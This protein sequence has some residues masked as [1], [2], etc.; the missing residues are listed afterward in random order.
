MAEAP[1]GLIG[2]RIP[3]LEDD[4]LT[5]GRGRYLDDL[6]PVGTLH[7]R[8]VRSQRA[9]A[10]LTAVV[11][12]EYEPLPPEAIVITGKD[13]LGLGIQADARVVPK[14]IEPHQR[15][16]DNRPTEL[17]PAWQSSLQPALAHEVVRYVGEPIAAVLHP[18]PYVV[19]DAA[20]AVSVHYEDLEPV[21][22]MRGAL[23]A[24][25][26]IV[27]EGWRDNVFI[28]RHRTYGDLKAARERGKHTVRI[29]TRTNRQAGVPLENRGCLAMPDATG[30]G[31]VL[32]T[33]SQMPHLVRTYVSRALGIPENLLRV[34]APEV[35]GGFG[36]KGHVFPD[37]VLVS[38]LAR[39][40]QRPV[41][42]TED[43]VE[44]LLSSIHARDHAHRLEAFVDDDGRVHGI[45]A[46]IV[47][48]A[49]AYSVFPWTAGS[50]SGMVPKVMIGPYDIQDVEFEDIAIA[51]NKS[52]LGTYR[53]VGRP[54]ATFSIERLMD[55]VA[56]QLGLDAV[57]VRRRNLITEFPYRAANGLLYDSGSYLDTLNKV[58]EEL[59]WEVARATDQG[60]QRYRRGVG[61]SVFNEQT[62][63]GTP[64]FEVRGTP[65]ETGYQGMRVE[66]NPDGTSVIFMGLQSHGQ[67]LETTLAQVM[68]SELGVLPSTVKVV[69]GDTGNSPYSVGTWGSRGAVLGGG[70]VARAAREL[71]AKVLKIAAF[72]LDVAEDDL[73]I[74]RGVVR[75]KKNP[76]Q[77]RTI[78]QIA[79]IAIRRAAKMP[80]GLAPGLDAL[81]YVDGPDRGTFSNACH[82]AQVVLDTWTGRVRIERY[83]VAEDCGTMLN[84]TIVEG[85][86]QGGVAQGIGN[87]LLE[88]FNYSDDGQPMSATFMDYLMPTATDVPALEI[89]HF[90]SPS[91]WTENGVKG[92]GEAGAI[93]PLA[94]VAAAVSHAVGAQ[95]YETPMQMERV[96]A[97]QEGDVPEHLTWEYWH[98]C[99]RLR[100]FWDDF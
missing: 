36:V 39:R 59:D 82:G 87:A 23:A 7:L 14:V 64:D 11:P 54:S 53:G 85:Q 18:D 69:H 30:R 57:E 15:Y 42:W 86:V 99:P 44:H 70:A 95:L 68:A 16:D 80:P 77:L 96:F 5:T 91:P 38:E 71:R 63:H 74:E 25:A 19:E 1:K 24:D 65:I 22:D 32:W 92:M 48:D 37:E 3:R 83:V 73:E 79:E 41:K 20:E 76:S 97:I 10:R 6:T 8:F 94:A 12:G 75:V 50:D 81:A 28:R 45:R 61:V 27:H 88:E 58:S 93:G 62:A 84:P 78:A 98:E 34:I 51:T 9:H 35:G 43:R 67:G 33:S 56:E 31:V 90:D 21:I 60:G 49:G 2:E 47:V 89:H 17:D 26:P 55:T 13:V 40:L 52:P 4:R 46:Q 66:I 29:T 100:G 72:R